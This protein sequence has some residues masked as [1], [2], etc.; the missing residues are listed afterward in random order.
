MINACAALII[1]LA[2]LFYYLNFGVG[3]ELSDSAE[4]WA[5]FGDYFGGVVNPILSFLSIILLIRSLNLQRQANL[6]IIKETKRQETIESQRKFELKFYN[7][8]ETQ[9]NMFDSFEIEIN[10]KRHKASRAVTELENLVF[11]IIK[12]GLYSKDQ[13][14][15]VIETLDTDDNL[16]SITRRFSLMLKLINNLPHPNS[17]YKSV[18]INFTDYKLLCL[19]AISSTYFSWDCANSIRE[20]NILIEHDFKSYIDKLNQEDSEQNSG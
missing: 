5:Q 18:L 3:N 4:I 17:E 1:T 8:L 2:L 7:M 14:K 9:K 12:S 6:S 20:S 10:E 19:I 16:F 15:Q 13:I 11:E